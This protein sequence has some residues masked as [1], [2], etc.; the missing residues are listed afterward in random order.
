[1]SDLNY[2]LGVYVGEVIEFR[3]LLTLSTDMLRTRNVVEVSPEDA[4]RH[5]IVNEALLKTSK[6]NGGSGDSKQE[7]A[8]FKAL[9]NEL[10]RKYLPEKLQCMVP[11]V[12]P[13]DMKQ[14]HEG[15]KDQ[16]W[17][18][19]LSHYWPEDDFYKLGHPSGH[20]D[21]IILTLKIND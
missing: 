13:T 1:M 19:D 20:S 12:R 5:R 16:L 21:Y 18:T 6:Y 3:Y 11:H 10:A 7:F 4:E 2:Q 17:D 8:A 14:F 15:L 9:N